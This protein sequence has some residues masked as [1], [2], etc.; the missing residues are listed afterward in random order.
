MGL[1]W[2]WLDLSS[3]FEAFTAHNDAQD[4]NSKDQPENAGNRLSRFMEARGDGGNRASG[5]AIAPTRGAPG[6][7]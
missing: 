7:S 3:Y 4:P 1:D 2:R 5:K 6:G